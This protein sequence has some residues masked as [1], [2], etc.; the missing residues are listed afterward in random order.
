[1]RTARSCKL[2][3][4]FVVGRAET[5]LVPQNSPPTCSVYTCIS[6]NLMGEGGDTRLLATATL[7]RKK[8]TFGVGPEGSVQV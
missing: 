3:N 6:S 2:I 1:M 4:V 8:T 7:S 5:A